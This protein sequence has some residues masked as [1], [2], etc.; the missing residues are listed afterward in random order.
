MFRVF[1][2]HKSDWRNCGL[3]VGLYAEKWSYAIHGNM[4]TK[5]TATASDLKSSL[6]SP[7]VNWR[8][9]GQT[10]SS[11]SSEKEMSL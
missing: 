3:C 2:L 8:R 6:L 1:A 4:V 9:T 5:L 10:C 11:T 7:A